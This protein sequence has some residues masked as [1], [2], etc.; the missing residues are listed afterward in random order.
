MRVLVCGG[1]LYRDTSELDR[2]LTALHRKFRFKVVIE[3]EAMGADIM[4]RD[5]ALLNK[6]NVEQYFA[7]WD[8]LG[9]RA[10]TA[11]NARMLR[12]GKPMIGVCF[13]GG[14]GTADMADRLIKAGIATFVGLKSSEPGSATVWSIHNACALTA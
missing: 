4:A 12:E 1:R 14:V 3:G 13:P 7:N 8:L 2:V 6:I 5:W 11:R 9:N 10:G